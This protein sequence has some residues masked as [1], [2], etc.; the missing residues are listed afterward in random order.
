MY[1]SGMDVR[2][3]LKM[4]TSFT[5]EPSYRV[6]QVH[7]SCPIFT[8]SGPC[9][10][11]LHKCY[12]VR[13]HPCAHTQHFKVL[14]HF[15]RIQFGSELESE[16]VCGLNHD[17]RHYSGSPISHFPKIGHPPT[18]VFLQSSKGALVC[19]STAWQ[20]AKTLSTHP[21]W[22]RDGV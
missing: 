8:T 22:N 2:W 18:Q 7:P 13:V 16:A 10:L 12:S 20:G 4:L 6:I 17:H 1:T 19:L 15:L 21:I 14:K 11:H 3:N 5:I 9:T